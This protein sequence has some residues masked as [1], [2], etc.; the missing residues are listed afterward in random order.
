M[1]TAKKSK[2]PATTKKPVKPPVKK[3]TTVKR[4]T[5]KQVNTSSAQPD[6]F[7]IRFSSQSL[8]WIIFG[9]ASIVFALW[10]YT[11]DAKVRDLY[12]QVDANSYSMHS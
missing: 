11:L 7:E 12:D 9:V 3:P 6:F 8:Y 5:K 4:T 1:A 2:T 10:L